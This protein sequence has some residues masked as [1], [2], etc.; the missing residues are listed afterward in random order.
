[1]TSVC[2]GR[3]PNNIKAKWIKALR[4]GKFEQGSGALRREGKY[5]CLG[6]LAEVSGVAPESIEGHGVLLSVSPYLSEMLDPGYGRDRQI[7]LENMNDGYRGTKK[8][9]FPEIADWIEA[10]L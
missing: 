10:N 6:V 8:C 2:E 4:S 1:M 5:C 3:L 9:S 7:A